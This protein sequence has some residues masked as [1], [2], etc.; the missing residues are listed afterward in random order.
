MGLSQEE[1]EKDLNGATSTDVAFDKNVLRKI[2]G[3]VTEKQPETD[4]TKSYNEIKEYLSNEEQLGE[5][6][7][8][9]ETKQEKLV[10]MEN[11]LKSAIENLEADKKQLKS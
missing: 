4:V 11:E 3:C 7:K 9:L 10:A 6:F 2:T 5:M 8:D 1:I